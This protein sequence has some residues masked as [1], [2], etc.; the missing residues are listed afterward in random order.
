LDRS[1]G[2]SNY[3]DSYVE[4]LERDQRKREELNSLMR[5]A[6][7]DA[8]RLYSSNRRM[9]QRFTLIEN[10]ENSMAFQLYRLG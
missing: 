7:Q 10:L 8:I 9:K 2:R 4:G 1:G 5:L 3:K 6:K